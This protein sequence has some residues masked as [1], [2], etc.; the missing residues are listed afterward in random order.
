V[1][2]L[3]LQ[4]NTDQFKF[5][6]SFTNYILIASYHCHTEAML[7]FLQDALSGISS[8]VHLFLPHLTGHSMRRYPQLIH[9]PTLWNSLVKWALLII[10]ILKYLNQVI[11]S[12]SRMA[13][14]LTRRLTIF[15]RDYNVK[16]SC[17]IA[18]EESLFYSI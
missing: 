11:K 2:G 10:V 16:S 3:V 5:I 6:K 1:L 12:S 17:F 9:F 14:I 8:N 15:C 18:T 7:N 4:E 13:T